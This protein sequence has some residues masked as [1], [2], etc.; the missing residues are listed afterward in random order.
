M[1]Q[2]KTLFKIAIGSASA[3][4]LGTLNSGSSVSAAELA[5]GRIN[6][7]VEEGIEFLNNAIDVDPDNTIFDPGNLDEGGIFDV[8]FA[9]EA[10][11]APGG[12]PALSFDDKQGIMVD[13][14]TPSSAIPGGSFVSGVNY[15]LVSIF[16][17]AGLPGLETVDGT[18]GLPLLYF[19]LDADNT[20]TDDAIYYVTDFIRTATPA[21]GGGFNVVLNFEGFFASPSDIFDITFSEV[22]LINGATS[23]DPNLLPAIDDNPPPNAL[24]NPD[25][26]N[27]DGVIVTVPGVPEPSATIGLISILG[28]VGFLR[29]RAR[30]K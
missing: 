26:S 17:N 12:N 10:F 27:L 1:N 8:T 2:A 4:V 7:V 19:D 28:A 18:E 5:P 13:L 30:I 25:S 24:P 6:F 15:D 23:I 3:L 22:A 9:T 21:P 20:F 14:Y 16:N 11:L 29:K